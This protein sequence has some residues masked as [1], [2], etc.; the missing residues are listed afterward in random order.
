MSLK[1]S[2]KYIQN[3]CQILHKNDSNILQKTA[4]EIS[5]S[6]LVKYFHTTE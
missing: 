6:Y 5:K 3:G 4:F 1:F 2:I